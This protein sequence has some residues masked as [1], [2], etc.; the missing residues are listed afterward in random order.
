MLRNNIYSQLKR[1]T[2]PLY[3]VKLK[4]LPGFVLF[5]LKSFITFVVYF[6]IAQYHLLLLRCQVNLK[7]ILI[8]NHAVC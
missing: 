5:L 1:E 2:K 8:L 6:R 4:L 3:A 7:V